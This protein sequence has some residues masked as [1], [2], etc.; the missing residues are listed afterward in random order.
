MLAFLLLVA[1]LQT[2]P[3]AAWIQAS[4]E[5]VVD[6]CP[7]APPIIFIHLRTRTVLIGEE[8]QRLGSY[9]TWTHAVW[10][11]RFL[12][13]QRQD[14]NTVYIQVDDDVEAERLVQLL[15]LIDANDMKQPTVVASPVPFFD[16]RG[17]QEPR[18]HRDW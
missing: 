7:G 9:P 14:R 11:L 13:D 6:P 12:K 4:S 5:G 15:N 16:P 18:W 3:T 8:R 10:Q 17:E 1:S 2:A